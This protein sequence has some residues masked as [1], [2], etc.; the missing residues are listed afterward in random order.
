MNK[1]GTLDIIKAYLGNKELSANNAYI[2]EIPL[3]KGSGPEPEPVPNDEIWYT[4]SDGNIVEPYDATVLPTIVSNIYVDGKGVIKFASDVISIGKKAFYN[5]AGFTS[6]TIPDSVT[7]IGE[8]A[9]TSC[10]SLTSVTIPNSVTSIGNYA[11][12]SCNGLTSVTIPNSVTSIGNNAFN[13]C[14]SLTSVTIPNSVTIIRNDV[15]NG[16]TSLTSVTI[17]NSVTSIGDLAF[18]SCSSLTSVTI[19]N[20]VT[21]IGDSAFSSC[22]GLTSVTIP[23]SVTSIGTGAFGSCDGLTSISVASGN[24]E[25]SSSNG[26]LFNYNKTTLVAYPA[27]KSGSYSIPN[28]VTSIGN[29]AFDGCSSLTSV[30]IPDR[31]TSIGNY[32]F[33]VCTSLTSVT[34]PNSVTSIGNYAFYGCT[35]LTSVTIP[36]SVTSIG[37]YAFG[38]ISAKILFSKL[39]STYTNKIFEIPFSNTTYTFNVEFNISEIPTD[40]NISTML[41]SH[42]G[43]KGTITYNI[44]TDYEPCKV[45]ALALANSKTIV[46]VYHIDGTSWT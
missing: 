16:C 45:Q 20:S 5:C 12:S 17:P 14:S 39:Y 43:K 7:S 2:G 22:N 36:N 10:S 9:F 40:Y 38:T 19:P 8:L 29:S 3:I 1:I 28:G 21:S 23:N 35:S 26:V 6:V 30:T 24:S 33:Y 15:F 32:A 4:S 41:P 34:I 13:G 11:F 27:G 44:Y 46:N 25:Y 37:N 42:T 18:S 31:V